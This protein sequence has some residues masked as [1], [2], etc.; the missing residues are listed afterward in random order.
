VSCA[1][2][3]PLIASGE[4]YSHLALLLPPP[5]SAAVQVKPVLQVRFAIVPVPQQS[6]PAAPQDSQFP[7]RHTIAELAQVPPLPP[8]HEVPRA[9]QAVQVPVLLLLSPVHSVPGEV[10]VRLFV[11]PQ[12]G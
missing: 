3:A 10:Q 6:S 1:V 4:D 5:A 8:Q 2:G 9:P 12:Q 7:V 11:V